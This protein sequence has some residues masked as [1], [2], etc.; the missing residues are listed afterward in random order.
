MG[1]LKRCPFCGKDVAEVGTVADHAFMDRD[2]TAYYWASR[3]YSVVCNFLKGGCGAA[4]SSRFRS[5][6]E[7]IE[8][9]N[10]RDDHD[11]D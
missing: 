6:E 7:A 4:T 8:A 2:D 9:W 11:S 3:S 5:E 1:E 10:R